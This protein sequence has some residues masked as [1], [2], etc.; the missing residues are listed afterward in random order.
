MIQGLPAGALMAPPGLLAIAA[1]GAA[2]V[3]FF[4][5]PNAP[6]GAISLGFAATGGGVSHTATLNVMLNPVSG[7]A[8]LQE[9]AG[10]A[11]PGTAEVQGLSA[12]DFNPTYWQNNTLNWVPD[13][14]EPM[15]TAL[16]TSPNQNI[17]APW[18]LEQPG[19][20]RMFYGG[21]DGSDTPNDR[22]YSVTTADF[23]SFDNRMLV[24]DHGDFQ[25]VNDVNVQALPDGS[26]HMMCTGGTWDGFN[27]PT[28]FSSPDGVAWN[29]TKEPYQA[30]LS[31][32]VNIEGYSDY[33]AGGFNAG[34][35]LFPESD[36]WTLYFYDN[37]SPVGNI[38][39]ATGSS[40]QDVQYQ[41]VSLETGADPNG[42]NKFVAGGQTWYLMGLMS[43]MPQLWYSLSKDGLTFAPQQTL[44]V[45]LSSLD[46]SM[47][48][49]GFVTKGKQVL[50][51]LYG[52][53]TGTPDN[54]LADNKIFGRWLQKKVVITDS[55]GT[56]Y[57]AQG[58]YGPDRQWFAVPTSGSLDG[59]V[60]AYAED[61]ITPLGSNVVSLSA[62]K[63]YALKVN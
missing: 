26:L 23:L 27:W 57:F 59:T 56:Q 31:D 2:R 13:V 38:Y 29:G 45:S 33:H 55:A 34:N 20:W 3:T 7:T 63:T 17:Y 21:W 9:T 60:V 11:N 53:N 28:Y 32:I 4:I 22:I 8:V 61:G 48:T 36:S 39:R 15:F 51:A 18:A 41:G 37:F 40:P 49:V 6:T 42:V 14:R 54:Q 35:V 5:P 25:H 30:R 43:N 12:G 44:F 10:N 16:T 47:D 46:T 52:A 58:S 19:G 50:G 62:G 24:I 1:S